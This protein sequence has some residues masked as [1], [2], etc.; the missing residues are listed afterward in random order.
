MSRDKNKFLNKKINK[1]E[2]SV[3][4]PFVYVLT[5]GAPYW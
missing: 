2:H 4:G 3:F 5:L 1:N